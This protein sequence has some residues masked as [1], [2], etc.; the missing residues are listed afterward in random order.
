MNDETH[1]K[2]VAKFGG[3]STGGPNP[4]YKCRDCGVI[5]PGLLFMLEDHLNKCS[6]IK[7]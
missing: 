7:D 1:K 2:L 3:T 5:F 6:K 4:F